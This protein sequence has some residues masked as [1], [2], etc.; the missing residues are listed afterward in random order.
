MEIRHAS[1]EQ[2]HAGRNG[3]RI[4]IEADVLDVANQIR[5]ID[6]KLKIYFNEFGNYYAI[7][8]ELADGSEGLVTTVPHDGLNSKLVDYIRMLGSGDYDYIGNAERRDRLA[9]REKDRVLEEEVGEMGERMAHQ[10]RSDDVEVNNKIF[11]P[12]NIDAS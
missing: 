2:V 4:L 3:K 9:D 10:I 11:L 6:P 12:R 5:Q 8:E 7:A 1:I